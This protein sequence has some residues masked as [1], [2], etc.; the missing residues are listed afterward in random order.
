MATRVLWLI[1]GL[2]PGGAER[3]LVNAAGAHDRTR[4]S[5]ECAFVVPEKQHM[6]APLNELGVPCYLLSGGASRQHWVLGLRRRLINGRFD[7]VHCH[8]PLLAAAARLVVRTIPAS[9]RPAMVTTEHNAWSRFVLPTRW[10]N[11]ITSPLDAATVA[12]SEEVLRSIRGP[13]RRR[14]VLLHHGIDVGAVRQLRSEREVVRRE[15]GL[16]PTDFVVGT[17]ANYRPQKDY[18]T[19]LR[20]A[21]RACDALPSLRVVAVGQGPLAERIEQLRRE[22]RLEDRLILTGFRPDAARVMSAF[23]VFTL[24]SEYEGLPVALME[25]TALGLPIV[26]TSV[27]GATD[28]FTDGSTAALVAVGDSTALSDGWLRL[29]S[30]TAFREKCAT[31]SAAIAAEF[32]VQRT[33]D[34]I[35]T[36]YEYALGRA[37]RA[38]V[39]RR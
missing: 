1:K 7:V 26:A 38:K 34:E 8:S 28:F 25:A 24:A 39:D 29:A 32:D 5:F 18:P 33:T 3:L 11:A 17:V 4:F 20:A 37:R 27:G 13:A 19:L 12:V 21:R 35:E 22:L 31:A 2:G 23:D 9:R 16:A 15:L 6:V 14:A 30:D 36:I 10:A